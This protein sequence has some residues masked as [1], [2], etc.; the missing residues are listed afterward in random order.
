MFWDA[1]QRDE[2]VLKAQDAA[3]KMAAYRVV[4][5]E[6]KADRSEKLAKLRADATDMI[7]TCIVK[8]D[9]YW[10]ARRRPGTTTPLRARKP[11]RN[12]PCPCGSGRKYKRCCGAN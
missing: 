1:D 10:K 5:E 3:E 12:D 4:F 7:P 9:A 11:R 8:I 6:R 2:R